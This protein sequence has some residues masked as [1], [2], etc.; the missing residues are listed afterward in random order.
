MLNIQPT[1]SALSDFQAMR[2]RKNIGYIIYKIGKMVIETETK[3][4][5]ANCSAIKYDFINAMQ[6][7][8]TCRYG[9][10]YYNNK[11]TF[12]SW[13]PDKAKG[14]HKM[15][16]A[17][18]KESFIMKLV[19]IQ[20]KFQCT[21]DSELFNFFKLNHDQQAIQKQKKQVTA[22]SQ[23]I[24]N[25]KSEI[26]RLTSSIQG[27]KNTEYKLRQANNSQRTEIKNLQ[28][29]VQ[30]LQ[31]QNGKLMEEHKDFEL[32]INELSAENKRLR[33]K[34]IDT[35][36]YEQWNHDEILMWIMSLDNGRFTKYEQK[37]K[38]SLAEEDVSGVNLQ[39]VDVADIKGWGVV[40]F[41]DKKYLMRQI[42]Q[43]VQNVVKKVNDMNNEGNNVA[44]TAYI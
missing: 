39:E 38:Q 37:L 11:L 2:Q 34:C 10:I 5:K 42:Q 13:A 43:L 12:V 24:S 33:L 6:Q 7:S 19:G 14:K 28:K 9:V 15:M 30:Q 20:Q 8:G 31:I 21:E 41:N 40:N 44:P 18:T 1:D 27:Y 26:S 29:R 32:K 17:A 3:A 35:T 22:S 23:S 36:N 16:Y 25:L 4:M